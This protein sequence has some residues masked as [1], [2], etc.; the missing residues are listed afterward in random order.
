[1]EADIQSLPYLDTI[2]KET[3]WLHLLTP[4]KSRMDTF[5][6]GYV[7]PVGTR[8]IIIVS[9][10]ARDPKP[11]DTVQLSLANL[12]HG[13]GW[14]LPDGVSPEVVSVDEKYGLSVIWLFSLEA[15]AEPK[16]PAHLYARP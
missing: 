16:L 2:V 3:L 9:A 5:F 6:C 7:I 15:V 1:M 11:Q 4:H 12:L 13:F 8:I 10:I 14:R